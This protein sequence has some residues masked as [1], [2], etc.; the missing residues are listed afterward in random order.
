M[1]PFT[2]RP[3]ACLN[4]AMLPVTVRAIQ[5]RDT[6]FFSPGVKSG[7]NAAFDSSTAHSTADAAE[8]FKDST[9]PN[10]CVAPR[11]S[12]GKTD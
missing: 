4:T 11:H 9:N 7:F 2:L 12:M 5:V 10:V 8:R 6:L 3:A 1:V